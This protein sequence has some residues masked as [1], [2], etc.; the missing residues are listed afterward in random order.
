MRTETKMQPQWDRR[1]RSFAREMYLHNSGSRRGWFPLRCGSRLLMVAY[2]NH[3]YAAGPHIREKETAALRVWLKEQGI[4]ELGYA[5]HPARGPEAGYTYAMIL[6]APEERHEEV[7][8]K[9]RELVEA[10]MADEELFADWEKRAPAY[11]EALIEDVR[12]NLGLTDAAG[13]PR[14][15]LLDGGASKS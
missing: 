14:L 12:R 9:I 8:A 2:N 4:E 3:P 13:P 15:R 1:A 11:Y 10:T 7:E 5:T 6:D